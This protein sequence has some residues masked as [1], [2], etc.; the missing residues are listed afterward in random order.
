MLHSLLDCNKPAATVISLHCK[1]AIGQL[2][3]CVAVI[4]AANIAEEGQGSPSMGIVLLRMY[5]AESAAVGGRDSICFMNCLYVLSSF[6]T[7]TDFGK[8]TSSP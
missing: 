3:L 6:S 4:K 5:T 7:W 8:T 2:F 1:L